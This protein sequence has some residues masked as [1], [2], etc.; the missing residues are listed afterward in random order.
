MRTTTA[1]SIAGRIVAQV[2]V[3]GLWWEGGMGHPRGVDPS[4]DSDFI[5]ALLFAAIPPVPPAILIGAFDG[6]G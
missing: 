2:I 6:I 3:V 4:G 5:G 1:I